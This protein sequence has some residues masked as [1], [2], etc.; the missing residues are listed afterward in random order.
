MMPACCAPNRNQQ[1]IFAAAAI[2]AGNGCH[3]GPMRVIP[4]GLGWMGTNTPWIKIDGEA[5]LRKTRIKPFL[6]GAIPVTTAQFRHFVHATGHISEAEKWG[7]SFVFYLQ[8]PPGLRTA[9][10]AGNAQWW[11]RVDGASWHHPVTPDGPA[12]RDDDPVVHVSWHDAQAYCAWSGTRL[13]LEAEWEHAARGGQGDIR[14]V[15]GDR[16]PDDSSYFPCNIWQ[17]NFPLHN[18]AGDGY[19]FLAPARSF[20]PNE[21]GLY[22]M[23]G[24]VWDWCEDMFRVRSLAKSARAH[25][26]AMK[27]YRV[28]KGGSFLC[29]ASYCTRYRIAARTGNAPESTTSHTGFRVVQSV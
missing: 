5:P 13:P 9:M 10:G 12:A 18:T 1:R 11:R 23:A 21:F 29:H 27:G 16:D 4:G 14:Y 17:G 25:A 26:Q 6:I 20:Q 22:G 3:A 28:I 2:P 24:N 7:W 19:P 15:W 8:L